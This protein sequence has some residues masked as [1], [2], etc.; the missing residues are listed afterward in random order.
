VGSE[1]CIRDSPAELFKFINEEVIDI[2]EEVEKESALYFTAYYFII[3]KNN[4]ILSIDAGHLQPFLVRTKED[5][6]MLMKSGGIPM[7]VSKDMNH[8]YKTQKTEIKSGDKIILFTDGLMEA[9]N[10]EENE[11]GMDG[12]IKS[13]K[14]SY[15]YP[16]ETI[17]R[18]L[19]KD[20]AGFTNIETLKDD[21]T[22]FIVEL[23]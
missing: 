9:R 8:L 3:D 5:K 17:M 13:I 20:L 11:F 1:M 12:I 19:V 18:N 23:K 21:M 16:G 10:S 6:M 4:T 22:I 15:K 2:L 14:S 7:G